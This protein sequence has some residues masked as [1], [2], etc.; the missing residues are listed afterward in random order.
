MDLAQLGTLPET[1]LAEARGLAEQYASKAS[2]GIDPRKGEAANPATATYGAIV[3]QFIERYAK[4]RQRTSDQTERI[5]KNC[6]AWRDKP[7]REITKHDANE[8]LSKKRHLG[9]NGRRTYCD[10]RWMGFPSRGSSCQSQNVGNRRSCEK[11]QPRWR[12]MDLLVSTLRLRRSDC[13][14]VPPGPYSGV[15]TSPL[16]F[17][18]GR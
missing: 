18:Q 8:P 10:D 4:P 15:R 16:D 9:T 14:E 17:L 7:I 2:K 11:S 1:K 5:L 12:R 3:D 13:H 6:Q